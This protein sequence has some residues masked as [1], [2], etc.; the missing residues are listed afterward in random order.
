ME[1]SKVITE[2]KKQIKWIASLRG[3]LVFFVFFSHQ[4]VLPIDRNTLFV[5]GKIGVVG[6]FVM[7]GLLAKSALEKRSLCQ[8]AFNR[9]LR[10]YPIYWLI[11]FLHTIL[12]TEGTYSTTQILANLTL[13]QQFIGQ[14]NILGASW[15]LSIMIILYVVLAFCKRNSIKRVPIAFYILCVCAIMCG[16]GRFMSGK[17]LPTAIFLMSAV[18]CMGYIFKNAG[19]KYEAL[20]KY[21]L[22]F[23][24]TL[25]VASYLSYDMK[26]L[27]YLL[28]YNTAFVLFYFFRK[29]NISSTLLIF[30]GFCGFTFF[31]G[32]DIPIKIIK[33]FYPTIIDLSPIIFVLIKFIFAIPFAW[34]ITKYIENPLLKW[35]K[36]VETTLP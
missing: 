18:G 6:F 21:I 3:L 33:I 7:S 26:F 19:E 30:L 27:L 24:I 32:S 11:V 35:G 36:S 31:L 2:Q 9:F 17:P 29:Y 5:F 10:L 8:Y 15:M 13:F 16:F 14:E 20:K 12:S 34:A 22:I 25:A 23:E 1:N 28:S 4:T